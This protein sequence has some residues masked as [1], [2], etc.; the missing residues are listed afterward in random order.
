VKKVLDDKKNT[1]EKKEAAAETEKPV[2]EPK[3]EQN[4]NAFPFIIHTEVKGI[5]MLKFRIHL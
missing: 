5:K 2:E 3:L 4:G 1:T